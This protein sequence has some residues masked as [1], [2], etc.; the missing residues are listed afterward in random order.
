MPGLLTDST[1]PAL[2]Q[3][4][5]LQLWDTVWPYL[6]MLA[7]FSLIVFVHELGHFTVA[8]WA[9]VRVERFAIGF[10]REIFGFTRGETRYSFN[11]LP[12]GGYVKML[13]QEDFDDKA[14][15]LKFKDDPTSFVNKPVGH[16]MAI[17]SAGVIMNAL[18]A[19][20]LF[21]IVFLI[22][23]EAVAPRIAFVEADSPAEKAGILPGDRVLAIDGEKMFEF[24][25]IRFAV[26]LASPHEPVE[27]LVER[28]GQPQPPIYVV[29]ELRAPENTRDMQRQ[30]IGIAPGVTSEIVAVGPEI[31]IDDP[32]APRPGDKLVEVDGVKVT[33]ENA[34]EVFNSLVYAKGDVFV[35]RADPNNPAA[36]PRKVP[37]NIPPV[38]A[39]Y[40]SDP[41]DVRTAGVLGL[42]PL[43]RFDRVHP[44][45]RA[46]LGG[47]DTG[48]TVL[49]WD[50]V[51]HPS[52]ADVAASIRDL[53]ETDIPFRVR[54]HDGRI[55][56]G[57]VRPKVNKKGSATMQAGVK[58]LESAARDGDEPRAVFTEVRPDGVAAAAGIQPG[59]LVLRLGEVDN[60]SASSV[61]EAVRKGRDRDLRLTLRKT[62][63]RIVN[64]TV[65]PIASGS[66][67]AV[68]SLVAEDILQVGHVVEMV[69]G[70]KTPAAEAGIPD[71]AK[72]TAANDT[73]V[74]HWRELIALFRAAAGTSVRLAYTE[75]GGEKKI[76]EF[77][78]PHCLHTL[79]GVGPEAR[80]L[81]IDGRES[82]TAHTPRGPESL[83]VRYH[84]GMRRMLNELVGRTQVTVQ[85]RENPFAEIKTKTIDVTADMTDPWVG[86]VAFSPNVAVAEQTTLLKANS[87]WE[88]L[89]IGTRKTYYFV[90]Q[91]YKIIERMVFSRTVGVDSVSG[92]LGI[93]D[94]GGQVA[95]A[96]LT[97]F[98]FF[99]AVISAN[100]AVINF[101]PLPIVDGG[102]MVFLL[103]EK[104]K[105]S[106]V[107]LRVQ[108]VTQTVGL[109]LIVGAF[110]FV[111]YQD[112]QRLFG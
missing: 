24:D 54:K 67:D 106:P 105:G 60:P 10:G 71:G 20:L 45:G 21:M 58:P 99:L 77:P 36:E 85:Y 101:L 1:M 88:A 66:I 63:G 87:A 41:A 32:T 76:A 34:S 90:V 97:K 96:G 104:I 15:E 27:F 44:K 25:E 62:D 102:L 9:G 33:E 14:N 56:Q 65:T 38:L 47:L 49:T 13:G 11:V 92:P 73:S 35:E 82:V 100:L 107:S 55:F 86:R 68:P 91:V 94:M 108:V 52:A 112:W 22:G 50:D 53:P 103:I 79:L 39:F 17:V 19:A 70:R 30:M 40:P 98:L 75:P 43:A 6:A 110:L 23:V 48:D 59:D 72:I 57:F 37:V 4:L 84:E 81:K 26:L 80:I 2:A 64:A 78:V 29:P 3:A 93:I 42:T 28:G 8:K 111:T 89:S 74:R 83:S 12:L 51:P 95:R 7:G 69:N 16:R 46:F 18:F 61:A 5:P 109:L 31:D